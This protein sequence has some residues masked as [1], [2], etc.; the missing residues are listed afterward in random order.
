MIE[1]LLIKLGYD[2][3]P[4]R[5]LVDGRRFRRAWRADDWADRVESTGLLD[6]VAFVPRTTRKREVEG[7]R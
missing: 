3:R 2:P 6:V 5:V 1:K 4:W 7:E